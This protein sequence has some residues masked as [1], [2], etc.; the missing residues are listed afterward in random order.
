MNTSNTLNESLINNTAVE[1]SAAERASH[2]NIVAMPR[3]RSYRTRDIGTGYGRSSGYALD[4]RYTTDW[5]QIR[6]R[7]A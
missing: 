2:D 4:K 5:G 6:F 1:F 7:C 3:R